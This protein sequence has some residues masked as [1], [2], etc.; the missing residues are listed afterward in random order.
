MYLTPQGKKQFQVGAVIVG[1]L[2]VAI[3]ALLL[4]PPLEPPVPVSGQVA[5]ALG[6]RPAY[7]FS[8]P[9][10]PTAALERPVSVLVS[11]DSVYV[12]DSTAG[13]VRVFDERGQERSAIGSGTLEVPV[14]IARDAARGLVYVTDRQKRVVFAFTDD[15]TPAGTISP[16]AVGATASAEPTSWAP[17]GIDVAEDGLIYVTDISG[18]HRVLVLESD[19]TVVREIGGERAAQSGSGVS[20]VLE[21]P[22][23]VDV[24]ED[25]VWV[26]DS[27]NRR[28]VVFGLDGQFSRVVPMTGLSR[29]IDL[30]NAVDSTRT[31][32][33]VV[34]TLAQDIAV[35]DSAG[36]VLGRFGQ[37]GSSA[38]R[39]AFPNDIAV[40]RDGKRMYIADTGNRRIQVWDVVPVSPLD[41]VTGGAGEADASA[42]IPYIAVALLAIIAAIIVGAVAVSRW[43]R[44]VALARIE[45]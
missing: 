29:G 36:G 1:L 6:G 43:R 45:T 3:A 18:R 20:V 31:L 34:D 22:N 42:R 28:V 21:Y 4:M 2:A 7:A 38:G 33:A 35:L 27:N 40:S 11:G 44:G 39:L 16:R 14:Y 32:V 12:V 23:A 41:A 26:S 24:F 17:L 13:L 19:G 25:E 8:F 5:A 9:E 10:T 30:L 15:G 37:P